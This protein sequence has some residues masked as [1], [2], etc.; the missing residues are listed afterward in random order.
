MTK[1]GMSMNCGEYSIA[2]KQGIKK[3]IITRDNEVYLIKRVTP[4]KLHELK[5]EFIGEGRV[6]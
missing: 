5:K 6:K 4:G 1:V 3:G 2:Q